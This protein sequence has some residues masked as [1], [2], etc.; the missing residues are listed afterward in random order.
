M[1]EYGWKEYGVMEE[2]K[3]RKG[4]M[5]KKLMKGAESTHIHVSVCGSTLLTE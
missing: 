4:G 2:R 1:D 5:M 3:G